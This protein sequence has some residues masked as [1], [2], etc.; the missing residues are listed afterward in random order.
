MVKR[1]LAIFARVL[2]LEIIIEAVSLLD[3]VGNF[4]KSLKSII[5]I[6]NNQLLKHFLQVRFDRVAL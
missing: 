5:W 3:Q 4:F 2:K 1:N 6:V